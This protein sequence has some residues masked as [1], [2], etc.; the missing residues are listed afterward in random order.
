MKL[1]IRLKYN[2]ILCFSYCYIHLVYNRFVYSISLH[3]SPL[4]TFLQNIDTTLFPIPH[5]HHPYTLLHHFITHTPWYIFHALASSF[6][7]LLHP[8]SRAW[9]S[10]ALIYLALI[11]RTFISPSFP[12]FHL[13]ALGFSRFHFTLFHPFHLPPLWFYPLSPPC[14]Y[15]LGFPRLDLRAW[16]HAL[17]F[18]TIAFTRLDSRALIYALGFPRLDFTPLLN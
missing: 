12:R 15:A 10:R 4:I 5:Y 16:I 2:S 8:L 18:H 3:L 17:G 13:P 7:P 14:I 6:P 1:K 9:I 11:Y